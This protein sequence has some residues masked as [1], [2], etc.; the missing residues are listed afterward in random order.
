MF[1]TEVE[2]GTVT[3]RHGIS[4][5]SADLSAKHDAG[6]RIRIFPIESWSFSTN[7]QLRRRQISVAAALGSLSPGGLPVAGGEQIL[8]QLGLLRLIKH[9]FLAGYRQVMHR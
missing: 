5:Y 9:C 8:L 2:F 1:C 7:R 6:A 4:V 3:G